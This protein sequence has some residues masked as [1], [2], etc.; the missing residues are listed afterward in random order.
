MTLSD[1]CIN[2]P[3]FTWVLVAIPVV[4]GLFSYGE[5]G[6]DLFPD[7][8]FPVCTVTT[9]LQGASVEEMET[10]VTKPIEDIINTVSGIDELRSTTTEGVSVVTVQ[11]LL[12]KNGDVGM[13]EVRDKVNTILA[14]LPDGTDPPIVDKFD[15]SSMPV[16]T[17]A[18][19]GRRDF[20]EVTELARKQ[21]KE[22]LE[23]VGGVGS[24]N[25]VGG[26]V[27]AMNVILDIERLAG[28]SLS[29]EDVRTALIRQN[30][31]VPGGRMDQGPR[32]LVLRTLG[33][34]R[35]QKEFN[36]LIV[37]NRNG[38]PI[39]LS[40]VGRAEDAFEEPRSQARLDGENAVSLVVQ[41]QSGVNTVR[42]VEDVKARLDLLKAALPADITTEIIRDQSRFI[43]KSIE[44]VKFHLL[45]AAV[46]V[47]ATILLFI[48]DWRTTLIATL[49]IPTS[50]IP[51]FMF[52]RYMDFT[53]NNITM[54]GLILAIGIVIDDAVVVHENIF[55]HMEEDGMDA[56]SAARKG[57]RDIALAVLAT[58][59]S[60]VVIFVPIAFMGGIA[61]RFFSSFGLTVA[62]AVVMSLF[63]S[64]TL[65]P[66]LCSRFLKLEAAPSGG[67]HRAKSKSGIFYR[68]IDG[69][70]GLVLAGA[71]RHKF[72]V[73]VLTGVV[74]YSTIP[75]GK[76]MG[77]S[78]I[79]R[80]DQSEYEISLTTPEGYS[81]ERTS[82]V[83]AEL[84]SRI[85]KL[86]GT[87]HVFTTIGQTQGGRVVKGE[88]DV[89]RGTIY[90]RITDLEKR[91]TA[92]Q[93]KGWWDVSGHL[94]RFFAGAQ[95]DQFQVQQEAR[96]FLEDYPDL[97]V[98]VNDVSPFQG[99]AR[100][101]TFQVSLAGPEL[102][103]LA[104][105]GD[106]LIAELKKTGSIVDLDTTLS[107]RKPE[108]QVS[109]DREAASDLGVPVGTIADTLR[110]LVG[111]L[112]VSKFRERDE[113]Y[114]VWLRADSGKRSTSQDLY[115]ITFPSPAVGLVKLAS[116][117]KLNED[118]GPTSI[119]RLSRERIVTVLGNPEGIALGDVI[120]Q[121]EAILK[122][123]NLPP[124]Y[125][126]A[127]TGQAKTLGETGH[128]FMV[129]FTLSITFMYLI[130]AAQFESWVQPIAILMAL[131]VTIPF[132]MLSLVLFHTPMDLYAMFGLFML[133]GIVKKNGILQI[134]ATNQLRAQGESR[135]DAI[136]AANHT[137]LR[138]ILMTTVM[139]VAAMVPIALGT[140]PGAGARASM[141]KVIIGGQVL[142]LVLALLVTPVFYAILDSFV[143]F[144]LRIGIRFSVEPAPPSVREPHH[145]LPHQ[146]N[147]VALKEV[148]EREGSYA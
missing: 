50:I 41:K 69:S 92:V 66:M 141:A 37:A 14:D 44:E 24:I 23:T 16:M 72:L 115:Q 58:S 35:T 70:Y 63:V 53:L 8:D 129:A 116:L 95:F 3:V 100:P 32:E 90:V 143:A 85:W 111:G 40:D 137:R 98:S 28:Y 125:S 62:F 11:F 104:A 91:R 73:V 79:P 88:G 18:V 102:S 118:R 81:L 107:L 55:R 78:L 64:F 148:D 117:A 25:L 146:G 87:E 134:D 147:G 57:T 2:R 47:S 108:V 126:Y 10:T 13:Q 144:T 127:F 113:Q 109:I 110:V 132:G 83:A 56:M 42:V 97:R 26:R 51:T 105:Y 99:G 29:V 30:L 80:D 20:R 39:R 12:S 43:K 84:E 21:I 145:H 74:I 135:H 38:Y 15:T 101:Q 119:E 71:M 34:L 19:S 142:S 123:M 54:L 121:A 82:Q 49:A 4:L 114:D 59:I 5:L 9:V 122:K 94:R 120:A 140:G 33:R 77:V 128:Y 89:T 139:L 67:A 76:A 22:R 27:R 106:G 46:L 17:I 96:K 75:I 45:L 112:P 103:Q 136:M 7:V 131:P 6:V 60:L 1:V 138:P 93:A 36:S 133:V 124:Q 48:R 61:G 68:L 65:T 86:K 52:M 130:L 31:E